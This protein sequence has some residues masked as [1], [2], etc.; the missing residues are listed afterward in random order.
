MKGLETLIKFPNGRREVGL[1]LSMDR[2]TM[3]IAFP[4]FPD[5]VELRSICGLWISEN[6]QPFE[7][8]A[9]TGTC[10]APRDPTSALLRSKR[11]DQVGPKYFV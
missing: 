7:V 6:G 3:R 10:P 11:V 1:V 4:R 2:E 5:L 9:L 8:E